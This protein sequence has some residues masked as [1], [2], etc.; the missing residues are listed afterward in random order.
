MNKTSQHMSDENLMRAFIEKKDMT[1][2]SLLYTRHF[3]PLRKYLAWISDREQ[4]KDIAQNAFYHIYKK[5]EKFDL[6]RSFQLWL[7][8]IAKNLWKNEIRNAATRKKYHENIDVSDSNPELDLV[9]NRTRLIQIHRAIEE[10]SIQ[11]KEVFVLKYSNNLTIKEI[12]ELL[13]CSEGTV[14]SRL[15]Y[16]IKGIR[17]RIKKIK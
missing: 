3:D 6:S 16:A 13:S 15:F 12:A 5:P 7:Y 8:S 11:Q 4:A 2:Y 10:L 17:A 9:E 1:A 14:K